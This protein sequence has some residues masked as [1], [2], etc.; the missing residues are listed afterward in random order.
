MLETQAVITTVILKIKE[1]MLMTKNKLGLYTTTPLQHNNTRQENL[2][3]NN[4]ND[5]ID[6]KRV[7]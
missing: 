5:Y 4:I 1:K 6:N 2:M 3:E 7:L